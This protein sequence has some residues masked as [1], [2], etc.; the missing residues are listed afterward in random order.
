MSKSEV[1]RPLILRVLIILLT[2]AAATAAVIAVCNLI[3]TSLNL[4]F[5]KSFSPVEYES[6]LAPSEKNGYMTFTSDRE[7]K[8][9][10][11]SDVHLGNCLISLSDDRK[12]LEEIAS[13]LYAEKPD[14]LVVTG[15]IAFPIPGTAG[16]ISNMGAHDIFAA[17]M[18]KLVVYYAVTLGN[19]DSNLAFSSSRPNVGK[20]Y[21]N[22]KY[23]H[24]L[25]SS[26]PTDVDGIGNYVINLENTDGEITR[27]LIMLD[28]NA[29][30]KHDFLGFN[31]TYDYIH[32]NQI[33]WY[34][35]TID[36]LTAAN[37]GVTPVSSLFL[38]IP[39]QE[40]RDAWEEYYDNGM[41]DTVNV[42]YTDTGDS[43]GKSEKVCC[44]DTEDALFETLL[45]K[46]STDS[47][48][49]GH[50]HVNNYTLKYK[51]IYLTY[52]M[53]SNYFVYASDA[54]YSHGC[55]VITYSPS[56]SITHK[57]ASGGVSA[58][59]QPVR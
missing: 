20:L 57:P 29:Y 34:S 55:T 6:Q 5:I 48:F 25:F 10:Q 1:K 47:V 23:P 40:Y 39:P 4:S 31:G 49:C 8:V 3:A 19:H 24:S 38:H 32:E 13:M 35:D 36:A 14:L 15:D 22:E 26:G 17:F 37:D 9:V 44:P 27:S 12:T 2:V 52:S 11:I 56:V 28:S 45:S 43:A 54:D 18:E 21:E 51:G 16:I 41:K 53:T 46:R 33:D 42:Q 30:E 50:D 7:I 59:E 58:R